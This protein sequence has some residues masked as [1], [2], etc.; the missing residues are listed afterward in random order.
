MRTSIS[1]TR[2][3]AA[4][5]K[6]IKRRSRTEVPDPPDPVTQLVIGFLQWNST[7][8]AAEAAHNRL[9]DALV[10][11]NDLRVS[12]S[13]ELV[14]LIGDNYPQ[15]EERAA[16]IR[17]ALNEI[18]LR[19]HAVS[20]DSLVGRPKKEVRAYLE[21]L[22]GTP[23][24][25]AA[26]VTLLC[27]GGHAI[28]V[29]DKLTE[30]LADAQVVSERSTPAQVA[31]FLERHIKASDAVAAHLALQAWADSSRRRIQAVGGPAH[32]RSVAADTTARTTKKTVKKKK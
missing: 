18:F 26:Q 12:H 23:P 5:Q 17:E 13:S 30:L 15:V 3:L 8:R 19:E 31:A 24:Y 4:L 2:K 32:Q 11:S 27:F 10:D 28:P 14:S 29:D 6:R 7:R 20:F 16:R 9:M 25:I 21:G 22:P 1:H